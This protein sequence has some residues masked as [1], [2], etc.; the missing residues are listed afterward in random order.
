MT[1]STL[2]PEDGGGRHRQDLVEEM[3]NAVTHGI[4]AVLSAVGLGVLLTLAATRGGTREMAALA[5]YGVTLLLLYLASTFYHGTRHARLKAFFHRCDH[6]CIFLLIAGTYTP[7]TLLVLGG[8]WGWA[9][10][11]TVWVL[12]LAGI[13]YKVR[14]DPEKNDR[15]S[16]VLFLG[17]GWLGVIALGPIVASLETGGVILLIAGGLAYTFGVPFYMWKRQR[18]SHAVWHLFTMAGSALHFAAIA[19]YAIPAT[20]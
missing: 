3:A 17:L 11:A 6:I 5:I 2:S 19:V 14:V 7:F 15:L 18:F 20:A 4:G 8:D 13:A 9:L 16:L 1:T 10:C 12:A